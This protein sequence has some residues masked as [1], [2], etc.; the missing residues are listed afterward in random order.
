MIASTLNYD[1]KLLYQNCEGVLRCVYSKGVYLTADVEEKTDLV[2]WHFN[3]TG[4]NS[5]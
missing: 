1:D 4:L 2:L 3:L 5:W